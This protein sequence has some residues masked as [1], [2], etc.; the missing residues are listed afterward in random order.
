MHL[1]IK[2]NEDIVN[3]FQKITFLAIRTFQFP[4]Q[5]VVHT[6]VTCMKTLMN[7]LLFISFFLQ[8]TFCKIYLLETEDKIGYPEKH[9]L[10]K[11]KGTIK[12]MIYQ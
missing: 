11:K 5:T 2:L 3:V 4:I 12:I 8:K 7:T 10:S 9:K 1:T 6:L